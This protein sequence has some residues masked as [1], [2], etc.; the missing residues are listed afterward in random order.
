MDSHKTNYDMRRESKA[1]FN[2]LPISIQEVKANMNSDNVKTF[3]SHVRVSETFWEPVESYAWY[4]WAQTR[5]VNSML[6][7]F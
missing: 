1:R 5:Y 3:H 4:A 7:F 2:H 6:L